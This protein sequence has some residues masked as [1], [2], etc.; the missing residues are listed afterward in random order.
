MK[1]ILPSKVDIASMAVLFE[2]EGK[3]V[4][5]VR[6]F[7]PEDTV[8][9]A[10]NSQYQ[11]WMLSGRLFATPGNVTDFGLI[12][13]E[14]LDWSERFEVKIVAFDPFQATQF[15]TRML[16]LLINCACRL[17][18]LWMAGTVTDVQALV[19]PTRRCRCLNPTFPQRLRLLQ[20]HFHS[21][22]C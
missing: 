15:S 8:F 11:G 2:R 4:G 1:A 14:L 18:R 17:F 7:L 22:L 9:S 19:T 16:C 13:A 10:G 20:H 21:T 3:V 6:H 5:F 12:E